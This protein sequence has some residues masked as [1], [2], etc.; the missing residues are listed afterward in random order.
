MLVV[1]TW[2]G[3]G[4]VG[5]AAPIAAFAAAAAELFTQLTCHHCR[6][7]ICCVRR[8]R[9]RIRL[10]PSSNKDVHECV[11]ATFDTARSADSSPAASAQDLASGRLVPLC[12]PK[13]GHAAQGCWQ[14]KV[15]QA[16]LP[17]FSAAAFAALPGLRPLF[18]G[19][20]TKKGDVILTKK[21]WSR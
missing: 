20:L 7:L 2:G 9:A 12:G 11:Q 4:G 18:H 19:E 13:R 17:R 3:A 21:A 16:L 8:A 15:L 10:G 14:M 5:G 6:Y 1:L